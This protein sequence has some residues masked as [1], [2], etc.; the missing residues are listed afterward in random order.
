[1]NPREVAGRVEKIELCEDEKEVKASKDI[2]RLYWAGIESSLLD[3]GL[4][5]QEVNLS[6]TQKGRNW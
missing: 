3:V 6:V 1:M 2:G 4:W 5:K